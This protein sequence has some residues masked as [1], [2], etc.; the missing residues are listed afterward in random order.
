MLLYTKIIILLLLTGLKDSYVKNHNSPVKLV[1]NNTVQ[2]CKKQDFRKK[3]LLNS[4]Y[5]LVQSGLLQHVTYY[6]SAA[7][8]GHNYLQ[9]DDSNRMET[10][11]HHLKD[12]KTYK[13]LPEN[14]AFHYYKYLSHKLNPS[15]LFKKS[16]DMLADV[17]NAPHISRSVANMDIKD[18]IYTQATAEAMLQLLTQTKELQKKT[19][20]KL[21]VASISLVILALVSL[22]IILMLRHRQQARFLNF[23]LN[24]ARNIHDETNPALLYAKA[25]ARSHK[26]SD[27]GEKTVLEKHIDHTMSLIRAL[28]QDLKSNKQHNL[29]DL[30]AHTEQLLLKLNTENTFRFQISKQLHYKRFV[31]YYQF[32]ELKAILNECITNTI[33]HAV[34]TTIEVDFRQK[35]NQLIIRYRDNGAGWDATVK[36]NGIGIDNI[37][38]RVEKLNGSL[39]LNNQYPN[40]YC[41]FITIPLR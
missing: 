27:T 14:N 2:D 5:T 11:L 33:K 37:K 19:E 17:I 26:E 31:S 15:F 24:L 39:E 23:K 4:I 34:F 21:S 3:G 40:G 13:N 10:L 28:A 1:L 32:S 20:Q 41:F 18:L 9:P 35:H 30:V 7:T 12:V 6:N 22:F 16:T 8:A 25:L 38:E 36:G 29:S